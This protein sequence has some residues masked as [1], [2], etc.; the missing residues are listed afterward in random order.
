[1]AVVPPRWFHSGA[2]RPQTLIRRGLTAESEG[3]AIKDFADSC[4][5]GVSFFGPG[6][7][8]GQEQQS[9]RDCREQVGSRAILATTSEDAG[10]FVHATIMAWLSMSWQEG[11]SIYSAMTCVWLSAEGS[12]GRVR[13]PHLSDARGGGCV[14]THIYAMLTHGLEGFAWQV[15]SK[16]SAGIRRRCFPERLDDWIGED[17]LVR[18][19]DLFVDQLDLPDARISTP[20][21]RTHGAAGVSSGCAAQAFHLRLSEPDPL[22]PPLGR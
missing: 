12:K 5:Q 16:V 20:C 1:M 11:S 6:K 18:V 10:V 21:R 2:S 8:I 7:W 4:F 13:R 3:V 22:Q 15:S 9:D 14:K 19:V 17:H